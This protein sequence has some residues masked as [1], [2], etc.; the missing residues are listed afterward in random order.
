MY[1][2]QGLGFGI[3][4]FGY[5]LSGHALRLWAMG[6]RLKG[7]LE[8]GAIG[9]KPGAGL[10]ARLSIYHYAHSISGSHS[11]ARTSNHPTH[12]PRPRKQPIPN[13]RFLV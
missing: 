1:R 3:S 2:V 13:P 8:F 6:L 5:R 7:F 11:Y 10:A 12:Y 4:G 9:F